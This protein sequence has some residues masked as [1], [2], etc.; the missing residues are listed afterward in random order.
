MPY[1][2]MVPTL[3]SLRCIELMVVFMSDQFSVGAFADSAHEYLLKQW[4]L[5][6]QSETKAKDLCS[7]K[8]LHTAVSALTL[9][10]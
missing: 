10:V 6:S 3:L 2:S 5:S 4:L 8:R 1:R 7:S 9:P